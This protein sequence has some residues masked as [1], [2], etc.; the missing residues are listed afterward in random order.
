MAANTD[1]TSGPLTNVLILGKTGVGKSALLNYLFG[2]KV[3]SSGTGSPVTTKGIHPKDPFKYGSMNIKIWDS[4]GL[5][6]GD[7]ET[8][9]S[10]ITSAI[11][12]TRAARV[13][14]WFHTIVYCVDAQKS[15]IDDFE[16]QSIIKPLLE[17][18][19][20][21][22]FVLTK[23]DV[24]GE[25]KIKETTKVINKDC[26]GSP[27][28]PMG[29][30]EIKLRGGK[31]TKPFGREQ[32]LSHIAINLRHNLMNQFCRNTQEQA[33]RFAGHA[34][35]RV[36]D[37]VKKELGTLGTAT[38]GKKFEAYLGDKI[39]REYQL[40]TESL[41]SLTNRNYQEI[42]QLSSSVF[43]EFR[44]EVIAFEKELLPAVAVS[45]K[46]KSLFS[47]KDLLALLAGGPGFLFLFV[48][49]LL[50][51]KHYAQETEKLLKAADER[52]K[53]EAE[54]L[55]K[56]VREREKSRSWKV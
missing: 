32:L 14:D 29:S 13:R 17:D 48:K 50:R 28:I 41:F 55:L 8:W 11:A 26:P 47:R 36:M 43:S 37:E 18:G 56:K 24:A 22:V 9:K 2:K 4:W 1:S 53:N 12:E 23:S 42:N 51:A 15:R 6:P 25:A 39:S 40:A 30:E 21:I 10:I 7:S 33:K 49:N 52:L 45:S 16:I 19:N 35:K 34:H 20:Q 27:V 46:V 5:E 54:T 3:A 44:G 31:T 38:Y